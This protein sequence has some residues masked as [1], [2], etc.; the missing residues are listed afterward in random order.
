MFELI[1]TDA[2]SQPFIRVAV[3][4]GSFIAA[5]LIWDF[6]KGR[7]SREPGAPHVEGLAE[8]IM[9][10]FVVVATLSAIAGLCRSVDPDLGKAVAMVLIVASGAHVGGRLENVLRSHRF[11]TFDENGY[12]RPPYFLK[13]AIVGSG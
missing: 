1:L 2:A 3:G 7:R 6:I 4:I 5:R 8:T 9:W 13:C 12:L 10:A 11:K